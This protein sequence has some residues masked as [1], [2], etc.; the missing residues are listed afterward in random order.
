MPLFATLSINQNYLSP[1]S[2]LQAGKGI[3]HL[4]LCVEHTVM[5]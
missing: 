1:Q 2:G 3:F 4:L 5:P